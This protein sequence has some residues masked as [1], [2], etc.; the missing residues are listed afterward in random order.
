LRHNGFRAV[1]ARSAGQDKE[2]QLMASKDK[3][4]QAMRHDGQTGKTSSASKFS[5]ASAA[6]AQAKAKRQQLPA[7]SSDWFTVDQ[8][9][10]KGRR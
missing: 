4:F 7:G 5:T 1:A 3:R 6:R 9:R 8:T 2:H 10:R